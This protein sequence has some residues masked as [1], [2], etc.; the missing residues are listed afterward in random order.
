MFPQDRQSIFFEDNIYASRAINIK[1]LNNDRKLAI[2]SFLKENSINYVIGKDDNF[3]NCI[4]L[5][6]IGDIYQKRSIRNFFLNER[7]KS[8]N[9]YLININ[10]CRL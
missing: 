2:L 6:K 3:P 5:N 7:R 1:S 10:D 8:Y 9:I 4:V